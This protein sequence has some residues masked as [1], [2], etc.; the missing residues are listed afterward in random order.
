[1]AKAARIGVFGGSFDPPH[2]GH[3]MLAKIAIERLL[4][5]ELWV[6]PV[7]EPVHRTLTASVTAEQRLQMVKIMF[8][9]MAKIQVLDWEVTAANAVPS[10]DTLTRIR[11][12]YPTVTPV[13]LLGM[14]AWQGITQWVG[15]PIHCKLCN[16]AVFSRA[17]IS[18]CHVNDWQTLALIDWQQKN[19]DDSAGHVVFLS[20]VLPDISATTIRAQLRQ[21]AMPSSLKKLAHSAWVKQWYSKRMKQQTQRNQ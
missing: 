18:P 11:Q 15:Y 10:C 4:L 6:I 7:G 20:D 12:T 3:W 5:D 1:M 8:Q 9:S 13:F 19:Y 16:I 21:G 14:D 2:Y 17:G